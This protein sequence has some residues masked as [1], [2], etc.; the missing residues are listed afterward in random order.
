MAR[1]KKKQPTIEEGLPPYFAT[2]ADMMTL[3]MTFFVLLFSM[4]TLDPVKVSNF[5]D[6]MVKLKVGGA[7]AHE[8]DRK[9]Q[10]SMAQINQK[11]KD[12]VTDMDIEDVTQLTTDKRGT[13]I[14][15]DGEISFA[16][17]RADLKPQLIS[18]LDNLVP[19]LMS[20]PDDL[21]P[22]L[23]EGHSDNMQL[24]GKLQ[25]KWGSN[26]E[27]SAARAASVV[28]HLISR[29]VKPGKLIASGYAERWPADAT[30]EGIRKGKLYDSET[31]TYLDIDTF[32][33]I[34]YILF[35]KF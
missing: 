20:N 12:I 2:F 35:I 29:G 1:K 32:I 26:W 11:L 6:R 31:S 22:I 9:P 14:E 3:L 19:E 25:E 17:G 4:S 13:A 16:G 33:L 34:Y 10:D 21:R 5:A 30:I 23:V 28:R 7:A 27:L 15:M 24:T 8:T 18:I